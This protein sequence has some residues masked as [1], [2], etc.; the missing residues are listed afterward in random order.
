[1]GRDVEERGRK[2][3]QLAEE[4]LYEFINPGGGVQTNKTA[5]GGKTDIRHVG[6]FTERDRSSRANQLGKKGS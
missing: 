2:K 1:L 3:N 5:F 6:K 4:V